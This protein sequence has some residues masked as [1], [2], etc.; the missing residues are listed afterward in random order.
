MLAAVKGN[1]DVVRVL[2]DANVTVTREYDDGSTALSFAF[3]YNA[4][5][6]AKSYKIAQLLLDRG[7]SRIRK[8]QVAY[9]MTLH[10]L[11]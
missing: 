2:L 4:R 7:A 10:R 6:I 9:D 3:A 5:D 8:L 11:L 1:V